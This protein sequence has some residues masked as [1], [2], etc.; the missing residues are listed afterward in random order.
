MTVRTRRQGEPGSGERGVTE[1]SAPWSRV[2]AFTWTR[3]AAC[4]SRDCLSAVWPRQAGVRGWREARPPRCR[5]RCPHTVGFVWRAGEGRG[6][7]S[8]SKPQRG[9]GKGRIGEGGAGA[10]RSKR[11]E[12]WARQGPGPQG[13]ATGSMQGRPLG[14]AR[15]AAW[16]NRRACPGIRRPGGRRLRRVG[17]GGTRP[18]GQRRRGPGPDSPSPDPH[19][20]QCEGRWPVPDLPQRD[21]GW[22]GRQGP[23][24]EMLDRA[25]V[26][27]EPP[28]PTTWPCPRGWRS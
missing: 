8:P 27:T 2:P 25:A 23:A 11:G 26:G 24:G 5:P 9:S 21:W 14:A 22:G 17:A 12:V 6:R 13:T 19:S 20:A 28:S 18:R 7:A 3:S 16:R 10:Q 1:T 4:V 15:G